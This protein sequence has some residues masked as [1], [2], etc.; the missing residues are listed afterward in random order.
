MKSLA[1]SLTRTTLL[2]VTLLAMGV[3]AMAGP[4]P[5]YTM[6]NGQLYELKPVKR[7][8]KLP[9]GCQVCVNGAVIDSKG[10]KTRFH[11]GDV[12]TSEGTVVVTPS[13]AGHGG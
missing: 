8:V 1:T 6:M 11:N 7:D 4:V 10:K 3:S 9:N 2:G 13:K 12:V 5:T